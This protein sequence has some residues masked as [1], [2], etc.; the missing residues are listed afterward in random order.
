MFVHANTDTAKT[1][2]Q[3][4][5]SNEEQPT[6]SRANLLFQ[7]QTVCLLTDSASVHTH[8]HT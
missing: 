2:F 5:G 6:S 8:E 7:Q 1:T 4:L 3:F